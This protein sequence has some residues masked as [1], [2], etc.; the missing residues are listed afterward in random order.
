MAP[1]NGD[2]PG[3][4]CALLAVYPAGGLRKGEKNVYDNTR[5][6]VVSVSGVVVTVYLVACTRR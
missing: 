3:T 6:G 4:R 2:I 1:R 5:S